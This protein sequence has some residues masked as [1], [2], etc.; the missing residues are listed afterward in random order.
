VTARFMLERAIKELEPVRNQ[1][2][3]CGANSKVD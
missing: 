1:L 3:G 2:Q